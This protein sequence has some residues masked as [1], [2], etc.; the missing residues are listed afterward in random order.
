MTNERDGSTAEESGKATSVADG[1][2]AA[3]TAAA[4]GAA[5][6]RN[7]K[8]RLAKAFPLPL[9]KARKSLK[10]GVREKFSLTAGELAW[11]VETKERLA[12]EAAPVKKSMLVRA[13]LVL[14]RDLDDEQL[15]AL[16]ANLPEIR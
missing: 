2:G 12:S 6:P 15:M 3:G 8:R 7:K 16:I 13:G 9:E 5:N 14:L 4:P 10:D 1:K 11:L